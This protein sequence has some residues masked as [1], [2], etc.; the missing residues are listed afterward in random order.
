MSIYT[1]HVTYKNGLERKKDKYLMAGDHAED[2]IKSV[3]QLWNA[4]QYYYYPRAQ[5]IE[6][7]AKH[8]MSLPARIES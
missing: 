8:I 1:V 5:N 7:T 6:Y 3:K 4:I 2:A